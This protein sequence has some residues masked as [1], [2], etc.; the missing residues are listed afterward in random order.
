[1]AV[2]LGEAD[3]YVH[4]SGL[5]EWNP[6]PGRSGR[7]GRRRRPPRLP[8]RRLPVYNQVP[9]WL[10]DLLICRSELAERV[11]AALR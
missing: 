7:G 8:P 3:V 1:M 4:R 9:P 6:A 2:L 5:W 11:L 10:P